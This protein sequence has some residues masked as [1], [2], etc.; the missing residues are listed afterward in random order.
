MWVDKGS[1]FYSKSLKLWLEKNDIEMYSAHNEG[2]SIVAE[3]F[4]R[5]LKSETYKYMASMSKNVYIDKL[6]EII[7]K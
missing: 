4:I 2:K 6:G 7:K 1:K 3:I 5:T